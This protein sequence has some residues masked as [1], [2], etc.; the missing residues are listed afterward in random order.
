MIQE[1]WKRLGPY[2]QLLLGDKGL[3]GHL[4]ERVMLGFLRSGIKLTIAR[5]GARVTRQ[6]LEARLYAGA[7]GQNQ[8]GIDIEA[9][10][11][12]GERWCFQCKRHQKW[13]LDQT[14]TAIRDVE[15]KFEAKHYFLLVTAPVQA[16]I[17]DLIHENHPNWTLWDLDTISTEIRLRTPPAML[18]KILAPLGLSAEEIKRFAPHSVSRFATPDEFFE[19]FLNAEKVFSH[20]VP[21]VGYQEPLKV[22]DRFLAGKKSKVLLLAAPGGSGKSKLLWEVCSRWRKRRSLELLFLN[23]H[24]Q[25]KDIDFA[26]LSDAK[27][28]VIFIDDAHRIDSI[29]SALIDLAER[30][31]NTKLIFASRPQ[32]VGALKALLDRVGMSDGVLLE[33]LPKLKGKETKELARAA[34]ASKAT[35]ERVKILAQVG[36]ES[37]FFIVVAGGLLARGEIQLSSLKSDDMV[38]S[39]VLG[40]YERSNLELVEERDKTLCKALLRLVALLSPIDLGP[41]LAKKLADVV[42]VQPYD[43]ERLVSKLQTI[44]LF[45]KSRN[46]LKVY[47]DLLSDF[48]AYDVCFSEER[49]STVVHEAINSIPEKRPEMMRN[50]AEAV[51]VA[52]QRGKTAEEI[53]TPLLEDAIESYEGS[54]ISSYDRQKIVEHWSSFSVFLPRESLR[55][56]ETVIKLAKTG[57]DTAEDGNGSLIWRKDRSDRPLY[58]LSDLIAPIVEYHEEW[59]EQAL[60]L[61]WE[62]GELVVDNSFQNSR[63]AHPWKGVVRAIG[64]KRGKSVDVNLAALKWFERKVQTEEGLQLCESNTLFLKLF[65][66]PCFRYYIETSEQE[67]NT[68]SLGRVGVHVKNT[69]PVRQLAYSIVDYV[70]E[71]GTWK[72][73]FNTLSVLAK[74]IDGIS[75]YDFGYHAKKLSE[76]DRSPWRARRRKALSRY[77]LILENFNKVSI[78]YEVRKTLIRELAYDNDEIFRPEILKL[79]HSI[80]VTPRILAAQTILADRDIDYEDAIQGTQHRIRRYEQWPKKL[81]EIVDTLIQQIGDRDEFYSLLSDVAAEMVAAEYRLFTGDLYETLKTRHPEIA[82]GLALQLVESD[83]ETPLWGNWSKLIFANAVVSEEQRDRILSA[84]VESG[85]I[86]ILQEL[87]RS[88]RF[89]LSD[90]DFEL[91]SSESKRL[92]ELAETAD[93]NTIWEFLGIVE[94]AVAKNIGFCERLLERL[95][96]EECSDSVLRA[97]IRALAPYLPR[98]VELSKETVEEVL[99]KVSHIK[100]MQSLD[101]DHFSKLAGRFPRETY[102]FLSNR[103]DKATKDDGYQALPF[104][105]DR[106]LNLSGIQGEADFETIYKPLWEKAVNHQLDVFNYWT[107]L[108]RSV[109]YDK[110]SLWIDDLKALVEQATSEEA[111][112]HYCELLHYE[113][114]L[115]IFERPELTLEFLEVANRLGGKHTL[116]RVKSRMYSSSGLEGRGYSSGILNEEDDYMES[117]A[118]SAAE[119]SSNKPLLAAFYRWIVEA[120]QS[121][122]KRSKDWYAACSEH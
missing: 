59:R 112:I 14:K 37:P 108:W 50:L 47:P 104:Y 57:E 22:F 4:F 64:F 34:L 17:N 48:L 78:Q 113:G 58:H 41:N 24:S 109:V 73:V 30:H 8:K 9:E 121:D 106:K 29:P 56:A 103:I 23:P 1:K 52:R 38:R 28:R 84:S 11:S 67:G 111:L 98:E 81:E 96:F 92:L 97:V 10:V 26:F 32:G 61:L 33:S 86:R 39:R 62:A 74:A 107:V 13:S 55:L 87:V 35:D 77:K 51:W 99:V 7:S 114:S 119:S 90:D 83:G 12:G 72:M 76:K 80:E 118:L 101:E 49:L 75:A 5:N 85:Q 25:D 122:K 6:V 94:K 66:I 69:E 15:E 43:I 45:T 116:H 70:I 79:Y 40:E 117:A 20:C 21:L 3:D 27:K 71:K 36:G 63:N 60:D 44:E 2:K 42:S 91:T 19:P 102:R 53:V 100:D 93:E 46:G 65:L 105:F 115:V 68:V 54:E 18:P 95:S 89:L 88:Y 31:S 110:S 120:E 82:L 16:E